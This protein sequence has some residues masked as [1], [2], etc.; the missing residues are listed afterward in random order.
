MKIGYIVGWGIIC[1]LCIVLITHNIEYEDTQDEELPFD[2][3]E[4]FMLPHEFRETIYK[5]HK[6][7]PTENLSE[8]QISLIEK[9]EK[10]GY[11]ISLYDY[12]DDYPIDALRI[13]YFAIRVG[14]Y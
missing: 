11:D 1:F 12:S 4:P 2:R 6:N 5:S 7:Y 14:G 9:F 3:L 10:D 13:G 8:E